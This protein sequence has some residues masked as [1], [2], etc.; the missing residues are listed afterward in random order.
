MRS[1]TTHARAAHARAT[2]VPERTM[3]AHA[4]T[5]HARVPHCTGQDQSGDA[6]AFQHSWWPTCKNPG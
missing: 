1:C 5:P 6:R 3:S 2:Q 4:R